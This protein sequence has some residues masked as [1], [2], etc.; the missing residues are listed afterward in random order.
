MYLLLPTDPRHVAA[1]ALSWKHTALP[2]RYTA[3]STKNCAWALGLAGSALQLAVGQRYLPR[4]SHASE[5]WEERR[6]ERE[7]GGRT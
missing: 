5:E 1:S 6:E 7:L 3:R 2:P 4:E